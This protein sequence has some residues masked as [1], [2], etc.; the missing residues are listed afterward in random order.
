MDFDEQFNLEHILF[1]DR[2]C[3]TCG[4]KK[5]LIE[6]FY[7]IRRKTTVSSSYSYECKECTIKRVTESRK[8]KIKPCQ[9]IYPDW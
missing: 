7:R 2:T 8:S 5:S 3:R 1:Q 4:I 9:D 6:D